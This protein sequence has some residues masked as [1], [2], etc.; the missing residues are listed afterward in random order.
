MMY[1]N[2]SLKTGA[3]DGSVIGD[4]NWW[5][6][7]L[8][9]EHQNGA[10]QTYALSQNYP[11]PFNP[12]TK[13]DFTIPASSQVQLKVYNMLGQEVATLINGA[14]TAGSHTATFDAS[15]LSSG[16]Y[17]YKLTAGSFVTTKKMVLV[18]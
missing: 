3:T 5:G 15:R 10:P 16:V 7:A 11:N 13:I 8:G 6:I 17:L 9:V 18:K 2:T 14:L 4:P 12:S 1:S